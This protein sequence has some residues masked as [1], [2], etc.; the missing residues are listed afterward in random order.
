MKGVSKMEFNNLT[1]DEL[2]HINGGWDP[3][4]MKRQAAEV[5]A[6]WAFV[7]TTA[8]ETYNTCRG[9]ADGWKQGWEEGK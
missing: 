6:I 8:Q 2:Q 4:N 1:L 5:G 3:D 9:A 7:C